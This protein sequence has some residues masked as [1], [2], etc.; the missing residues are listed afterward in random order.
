M[1][2]NATCRTWHLE[3]G[4]N[5]SQLILVAECVKGHG[6]LSSL[7][8]DLLNTRL[9]LNKCFHQGSDAKLHPN[10]GLDTKAFYP[11]PC[12]EAYLI[13]DNQP[14]VTG[15]TTLHTQ[16]NWPGVDPVFGSIELEQYIINNDGNLNFNWQDFTVIGNQ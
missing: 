15:N 6:P 8:S 9:D 12:F 10:T 3:T 5:F 11:D 14:A 2:F 13:T 4:Q 16:C 1:G 7:E